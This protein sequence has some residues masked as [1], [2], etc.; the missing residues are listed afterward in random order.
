[1]GRRAGDL[2]RARGVGALLAVGGR[3][4][5]EAGGGVRGVGVGHRGIDRPAERRRRR[6]IVAASDHEPERDARED[7][8]THGARPGRSGS[9]TRG[10][11][12]PVVMR[13]TPRDARLPSP[14]SRPP[15]R[16]RSSYSLNGRERS[17]FP[18]RAKT[19]LPT[20][21]ATVGVAGSPTPPILSVLA[22]IT[23]S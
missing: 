1:A 16:N 23:V 5:W 15:T 10:G 20:A 4:S 7:R 3:C 9:A 14:T 19:A 21:G 11:S 6:R 22:T 18:V 8:Q 17:R 2:A 13:R 12:N